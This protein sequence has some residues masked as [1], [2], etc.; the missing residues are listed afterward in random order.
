VSHQVLFQVMF[1]LHTAPRD[2]PQL[3]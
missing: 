1:Q 3:S 2:L